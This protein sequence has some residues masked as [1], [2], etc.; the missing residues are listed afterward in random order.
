METVT[1]LERSGREIIETFLL[2]NRDVGDFVTISSVK[3]F[4]LPAQVDLVASTFEKKNYKHYILFRMMIETGITPV[5][6][7]NLLVR[8]VDLEARNILVS[9]NDIWKTTRQRQERYID[10]D[11]TLKTEIALYLEK[12]NSDS[13]YLFVSTKGGRYNSLGLL[14]IINNKT[15]GLPEIRAPI[16]SNSIKRTFACNKIRSKEKLVNI[17]KQLGHKSMAITLKYIFDCKIKKGSGFLF[18]EL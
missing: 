15:I 18:K 17:S 10:F 3:K 9:S 1:D 7:A 14:S 8:N 5:E 16:G 2:V 6:A 12:R 11:K 13:E 4:L